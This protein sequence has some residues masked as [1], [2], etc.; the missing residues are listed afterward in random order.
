MT[1][2][3]GLFKFKIKIIAPDAS[4]PTQKCQLIYY[5][6]YILSHLF[7]AMN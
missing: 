7:W 6:L 2:G 5:N 1:E 3:A 4:A